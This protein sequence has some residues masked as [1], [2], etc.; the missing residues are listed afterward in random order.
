MKFVLLD[1]RNLF[2]PLIYIAFGLQHH[3]RFRS[4]YFN[5]N[6]E[7]TNCRAC[8]LHVQTFSFTKILISFQ[9]GSNALTAAMS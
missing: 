3:A 4:F 5:L 7:W 9:N 6:A 1:F 8:I 2:M